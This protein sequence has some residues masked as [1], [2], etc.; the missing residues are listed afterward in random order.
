[1]IIIEYSKKKLKKIGAAITDPKKI[2]GFFSACLLTV[3]FIFAGIG[4][5]ATFA[6]TDKY[7]NFY[8]QDATLVSETSDGTEILVC[9][10]TIG[11]TARGRFAATIIL[12]LGY[13]S[14][15]Y[16]QK[17]LE[18]KQ[19]GINPYRVWGIER[20]IEIDPEKKD[21]RVVGERI[22]SCDGKPLVTYTQLDKYWKE[23]TTKPTPQKSVIDGIM[24]WHNDYR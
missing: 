19:H 17:M 13:D 10:E 11:K 20:D 7:V 18:A 9:E 23:T 8:R 12:K 22:I 1:M 16:Y 15:L 21:Y 2:R 3:I 24:K 5:L 14:E 6:Y 4:M